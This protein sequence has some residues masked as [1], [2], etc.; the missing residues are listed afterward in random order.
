MALFKLFNL[1]PSETAEFFDHIEAE[2][3][4][5]LRDGYV[6]FRSHLSL[7]ALKEEA[8]YLDPHTHITETLTHA[9]TRT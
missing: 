4:K 3:V 1:R 2:D 9:K 5:Q 6:E 8:E 7:S